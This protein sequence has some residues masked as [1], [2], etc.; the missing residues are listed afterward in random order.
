M[1]PRILRINSVVEATGLSRSTIYRFVSASTFPPP[2]KLGLNSVG[3]RVEDVEAWLES[4]PKAGEAG[5]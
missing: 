5:A 2:V 4:R 3:W 1:A